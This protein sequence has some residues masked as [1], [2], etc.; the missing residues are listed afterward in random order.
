MFSELSSGLSAFYQATVDL[1]IVQKVTTYTGSGLHR[2]VLG[3][4]VLGGE[5]YGQDGTISRDQFEA[6]IAEWYG[7]R[8]ADLPEHFPGL[9][10]VPP[11]KLPF[12]V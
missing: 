7:V 8:V 11:A 6:A 9:G 5:I 2:A 1:G 10:G 4:S 3:G 12:M